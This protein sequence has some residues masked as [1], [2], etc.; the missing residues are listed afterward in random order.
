MEEEGGLVTRR[1]GR[2]AELKR[3]EAWIMKEEGCLEIRRGEGG[4]HGR[5]WTK[6]QRLGY[7]TKLK[8]RSKLLESCM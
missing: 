8:L 6:G 7:M 5:R 4:L 2:S 3:K 1:V